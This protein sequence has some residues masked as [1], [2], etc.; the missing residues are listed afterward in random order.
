MTEKDVEKVA[1]FLHRVVQ[2]S[3][4][5]QKEAGSKKLADFVTAYTKGDGE[6]AK[7]V[8]DLKAEVEKFACSFPLPGV[9]DTVS[10][11]PWRSTFHAH[12]ETVQ[13]QAVRLNFHRRCARPSRCQ[14]FSVSLPHES[15]RLI[16]ATVE[17]TPGP[18]F[19]FSVIHLMHMSV[20]AKTR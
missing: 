8:A 19:G 7:L 13:H 11:N 20:Y 15:R 3:L 17:P 18:I 12:S 2:I 1:E 4:T 5:A 9:P 6:S 14:I 10:Q 16:M